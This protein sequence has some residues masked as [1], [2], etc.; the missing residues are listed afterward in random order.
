MI[1]VVILSAIG[2]GWIAGQE[3][4]TGGMGEKWE[5]PVTQSYEP[6]MDLIMSDGSVIFTDTEHHLISLVDGDGRVRW[7]HEFDPNSSGPQIFD[8]S[9]YF[10]NISASGNY[11]LNCISLDGRGMSSTPCP[12]IQSFFV[13]DDGRT[14]GQWS[15]RNVSRSS[16]YSIEGG[17]VIWNLTENGS[18]SVI[19]VW[20]N[21]EVLLMHAVSHYVITSFSQVNVFDSEELLMIGPNGSSEWKI[22]CKEDGPYPDTSAK[23]ASNGTIVLDRYVSDMI[24]TD[25]YDMSGHLMWTLCGSYD[26]YAQSPSFFECQA[27]GTVCQHQNVESVFKV[28]PSNSSNSWT[29]YLNDTWGGSLYE[30][31]GTE[32]F[33][34]SDGQAFGL[35]SN[36]TILWHTD[37]AVTGTAR[38]Y[39]DPESGVLVQSDGAVTEIGKDG[40][41]WTYGGIDSPIVASKLGY[42]DTVYVLTDDKFIVLYKPTV[43]MPSEYLI[44]LISVDLLVA[45]S[46][47]LW[48]TDRMVLKPQ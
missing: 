48:I 38:S 13:G 15:E 47:G 9:V 14:Y 17:S 36:G 32:M 27:C 42:N 46:S 26:S 28:D 11:Y 39:V 24:F 43:S 20:E 30:L 41:F 45:L 5:M 16:I 7:S 2:Y 31:N 19:K 33:V 37:T 6:Q 10:T 35:D 44:A 12:P 40:S 4:R 29:T 34:S 22:P 18:F 3:S 1:L 23:I 21:G 8:G 25:G